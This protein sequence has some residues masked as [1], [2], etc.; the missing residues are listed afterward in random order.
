MPS[1][2]KKQIIKL[3]L[4]IVDRVVRWYTYASIDDSNIYDDTNGFPPGTT[5]RI[6][7]RG[8]YSSCNSDT[9]V[10]RATIGNYS[11]ISHHVTIG[12][13]DHIFTN[14]S[15]NDSIYSKTKEHLYDV[16]I[17]DNKYCVKI[18]H[19]VWIGSYS[20]V[21][22]GVEIGNGAIVAAGSVVTKSV[23]AYAVVAGN[24]ARIIKYRFNE[25]QIRKLESL[26][27]FEWDLDRILQEKDTLEK[28]VNFK[29][30]DFIAKENTRRKYLSS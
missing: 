15:I 25:K 6:T 8:K 24:P 13:R 29:L 12:P 2:M 22:R 4:K 3:I 14:F 9:I 16:G 10:A 27:W 7:K 21:L 5:I 18:G 17:W 19:D 23:P 26:K 30:S 11:M 1:A 20:I 28:L